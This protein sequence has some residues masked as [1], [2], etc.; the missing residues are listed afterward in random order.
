MTAI[1][2]SPIYFISYVSY[3]YIFLYNKFNLFYI[4]FIT[5]NMMLNTWTCISKNGNFLQ[6]LMHTPSKT[7]TEIVATSL[8]CM[9]FKSYIK[10]QTTNP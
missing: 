2:L 5:E 3:S 4:L 1:F 7:D 6:T 8:Q 10:W 9:S